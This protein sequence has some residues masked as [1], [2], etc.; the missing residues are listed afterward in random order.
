MMK[1]NKR[2]A[3]FAA[4]ALAALGLSCASASSL[5]QSGGAD[6][7]TRVMDIVFTEL[8]KQIMSDYYGIRTGRDGDG[9][10]RAPDREQKAKKG[11]KNKKQKGLPPGLARKKSL[12]PGLARQLERKGTLPPGLAKRDLPGALTTA[13]PDPWPGTERKVVDNDIVLLQ[14]GTEL[15]LDVLRDVIR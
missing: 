5:A 9:D 6:I 15:I 1:S 12:P 4:V 10:T 7:G 3:L 2:P 14:K 11:K 13:L 8:E